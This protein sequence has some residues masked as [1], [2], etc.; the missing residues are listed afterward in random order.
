[1]LDNTHLI[2][3]EHEGDAALCKALRHGIGDAAL[4]CWQ[5][6]HARQGSSLFSTNL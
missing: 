1:M 5:R 6:Q 3:V 2:Q 4:A